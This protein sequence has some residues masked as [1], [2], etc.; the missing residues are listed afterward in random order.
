MQ[1]TGLCGGI[2][3]ILT[4]EESDLGAYTILGQTVKSC[5]RKS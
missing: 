3:S 1:A 4:M 5:G 2:M